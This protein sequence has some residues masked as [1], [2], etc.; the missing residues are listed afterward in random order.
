MTFAGF[1]RNV[2]LVESKHPRKPLSNVNHFKQW[3]AFLPEMEPS[4]GS[5]C[6]ADQPFASQSAA[7]QSPG[8]QKT[9]TA[10][11]RGTTLSEHR[12][13]SATSPSTRRDE[14]HF[15]SK[16]A[17]STTCT[18]TGITAGTLSPF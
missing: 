5:T 4:N 18:S 3:H 2:R 16:I 14:A 8:A 15:F 7:I 10:N 17:L 1:N 9:Q 11:N 6:T 13:G 12:E